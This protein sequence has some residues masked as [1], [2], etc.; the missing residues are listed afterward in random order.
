[1]IR[2]PRPVP[3]GRLGACPALVAMLCAWLPAVCAA[4]DLPALPRQW[5]DTSEIAATG[6]TISVP[7][8][9]SFQSALGS[10]Q[11]GDVILLQAGAVFTGPFI[12]PVKQGEGWVTVRSSA[13]DEVLPPAGARMTPAFAAQLPK[14]V[15]RGPG[16]ALRTAPGA[17]HYR[18]VAVEFALATSTMSMNS[19]VELGDG[20]RDQAAL[21]S[22]PHHLIF[23]RVYA[24]GTA[25]GHLRRAFALNSA[26]T[27]I[28][29]S[30]VSDCHQEMYDTQAIGGWNGPGPFKIVNNYLEASGENLMFG[31]GDPSIDRLV[32]SDIEI[33]GNHFTKPLAWKIGHPTYA[34]RPW[35]VKNLFELKNAQRVVV[36]GNV[37]EHNWP[38]SQ[39]GFAILFTVRNQDGAA[40][41]STVSDVTFTHNIV[42]HVAAGINLHNL[43]DQHPSQPTSR[44]LIQHNLFHDVGT[45]TWGGP[46]IFFQV[47]GGPADVTIDHNT[48]MQSGHII[49]AG[50]T[51]PAPRFVFTSNLA[52]HNEYGVGGDNTYGNP[53][54]TLRTYFPGARL[55]GNVLIGGRGDG[56]PSGNQFP[57]S[58][59]AVGFVSV[60]TG[61][62]RLRPTSRYRTVGADGKAAGADI[63]ALNVATAGALSGTPAPA[64]SAVDRPAASRERR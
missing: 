4:A 25:T 38:H 8:G 2:A 44:I 31:G 59:A 39:N 28:M 58:I 36:D 43:D 42:R 49:A 37:F 21:A 62:Y 30:Y 64:A 46:G 52:L 18:F 45:P 20:G 6:R 35:S 32:P 41:W 55:A 57:P 19:L 14:I 50:E 24:H 15:S 29:N 63:D 60:E 48:M 26:N 53:A 34:G 54:L 40:P 3:V 10:A 47:N 33:R 56:Y 23:D 17:H 16:P 61:D 1:V 7:A 5:I 22:V 51:T 27:A 13:P 11:P 12:L 9:G